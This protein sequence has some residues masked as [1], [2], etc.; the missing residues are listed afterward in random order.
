VFKQ[1]AIVVNLLITFFEHIQTIYTLFMQCSMRCLRLLPLTLSVHKPFLTCLLQR[2]LYQIDKLSGPGYGHCPPCKAT[3]L[4]FQEVTVDLIGPWYVTL[5]NKIYELYALTC[6]DHQLE[7]I[8]SVIPIVWLD[9][10]MQIIL[11]QFLGSPFL[12]NIALFAAF[13]PV[14]LWR[15]SLNIWRYLGCWQCGTGRCVQFTSY[16]CLT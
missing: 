8:I 6:I 4:S 2:D 10:Y 14:S 16:L 1:L 15:F 12:A 13:P 7:P 5:P 9:L 11:L 3:A